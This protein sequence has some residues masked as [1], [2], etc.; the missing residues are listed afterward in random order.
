M[1]YDVCESWPD[2]ALRT[3]CRYGGRPKP[4]C[5]DTV[6]SGQQFTGRE[7]PR[8]VCSQPMMD[9]DTRGELLRV[10]AKASMNRCNEKRPGHAGPRFSCP[11]TISGPMQMGAARHHDSP[12]LAAAANRQKKPRPAQVWSGRRLPFVTPVPRSIKG[13]A[14]EQRQTS[15]WRKCEAAPKRRPRTSIRGQVGHDA[16][17]EGRHSKDGHPQPQPASWQAFGQDKIL[18]R[19][20][21]PR[22]ETHMP[23]A[24]DRRFR[25]PSQTRK[26]SVRKAGESGTAPLI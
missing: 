3:I 21:E 9:E 2:K 18:S 1:P 6:R 26:L 20:P 14:P 23:S 8:A 19:I 24:S 25:T 22:P 15:L 5:T 7:S 10:F 12:R 4:Q 16:H 11:T 17:P 13:Q